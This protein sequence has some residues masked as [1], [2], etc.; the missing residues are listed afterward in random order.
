MDPISAVCY[1]WIGRRRLTFLYSY[2]RL[3]KKLLA[4]RAGESPILNMG[5]RQVSMGGL[6][7]GSI[8][9]G[10]WG[11]PVCEHGVKKKLRHTLQTRFIFVNI[12]YI[13]VDC[14]LILFFI[15][16]ERVIV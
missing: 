10:Y 6:G 11:M 1:S 2:F 14:F 13:E 4:G 3:L 7:T 12:T 8:P 15:W 16:S 5:S 9:Y